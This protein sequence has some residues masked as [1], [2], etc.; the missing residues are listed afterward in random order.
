MGEWIF[1]QR[2]AY[3]GQGINKITEE[4]IKL[5][6]DIGMNWFSDNLNNKLQEEEITSKNVDKKRKEIQNRFYSVLNQYDDILPTNKELNDAF[7][8]QLNSSRKR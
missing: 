2:K 1:T 4:Q 7:L 6:E 5:L 8:E 3:K